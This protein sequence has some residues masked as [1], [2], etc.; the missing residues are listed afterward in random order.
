[1]IIMEPERDEA[2]EA[3]RLAEKILAFIT[4]KII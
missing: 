2:A 4:A 1:M 3:M